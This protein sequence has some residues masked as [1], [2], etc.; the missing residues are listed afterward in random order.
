MKLA[1]KI[2]NAFK[3]LVD[4]L[5]WFDNLYEKIF[6]TFYQKYFKTAWMLLNHIKKNIYMRIVQVFAVPHFPC[7]VFANI[8]WATR[9]SID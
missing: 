7:T 4:P 8:I 2:L 1:P 6:F 9:H 5:E 3:H